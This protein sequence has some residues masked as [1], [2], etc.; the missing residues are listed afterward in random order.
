M[1][2]PVSETSTATWPFDL[3]GDAERAARRHG[4]LGVQKQ[5]KKDLLQF[6]GVAQNRRQVLSS[7]EVSRSNLGGAEL[8][9]QQLQRVLD[10]RDSDR[11][12]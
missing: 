3:G 6:A 10:N 9:F 2:E 12:P 11:E 8:V 7:S 1:P 5:V 4:V